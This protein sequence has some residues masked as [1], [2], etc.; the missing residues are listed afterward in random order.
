MSRSNRPSVIGAITHID[1]AHNP[2]NTKQHEQQHNNQ[3][4]QQKQQPTTIDVFYCN[5]AVI[6][7]LKH[8]LKSVCYYGGVVVASSLIASI[9]QSH[10]RSHA[11]RN[12][13]RSVLFFRLNK[14]RIMPSHST[15]STGSGGGV[16]Q[17]DPC[18][19]GFYL[20]RWSEIV[21]IHFQQLGD[22]GK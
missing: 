16:T 18:H 5:N 12:T 10:S 21:A 14:S 11:T 17:F 1:F 19:A 8:R 22:L 13:D 20:G 15:K 7:H 3:P 6:D 4:W 2:N 9:R